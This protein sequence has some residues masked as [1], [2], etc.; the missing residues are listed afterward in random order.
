[1][2]G[3]NLRAISWGLVAYIGLYVFQATLLTL[4]FNL[5][6]ASI[7]SAVIL[8]QLLGLVSWVLA[9]YVAG[10]KAR[11]S[12]A[13]HGL[14]VGGAGAVL[15]LAGALALASMFGFEGAG[16]NFF[17]LGIGWVVLS[18]IFC[19]IDRKSVV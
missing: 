16:P 17:A 3:L 9:G 10:R 14:T 15:L 6:A 19:G 18:C 5:A 11:L 8:S 1:M 4:V 12:G 7:G 13:L 2:T